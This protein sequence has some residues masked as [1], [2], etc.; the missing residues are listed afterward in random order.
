MFLCPQ[1]VLIHGRVFEKFVLEGKKNSLGSLQNLN[2]F[3]WDEILK[4]EMKENT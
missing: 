2:T 1:V 4:F 3:Q